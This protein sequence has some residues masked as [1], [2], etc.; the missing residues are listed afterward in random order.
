MPI[1]AAQLGALHAI[2]AHF[3]R[4]DEPAIV[5][6][7]TG[8]GKTVIGAA[9][10]Y[11]L[12]PTGRVLYIVPSRLLRR[13]TARLLSSQQQLRDVGMLP[14]EGTNPTVLEVESIPAT[15]DDLLAADVVVGLPQSLTPLVERVPPPRDLFGV[16]IVDEAHHAPAPTWDAL[17]TAFD[18]RTVLLTA[19]PYRRDLRELPGRLAY[20]YPLSKA[21]SED[22]YEPVEFVGV[23]TLGL[24]EALADREVAQRAVDLLRGPLHVG[25]DSRLLVRAK[26]KERV[27]DLAELY[28]KLG[29]KINVVHGDLQP[30]SVEA[31]IQEVRDGTA[32]GLAFVGVLGEGFDCPQ[33]KIGAYHDKHRS[34]PVTLQFLGRLSRRAENTGPAQVVSA[35]ETLKSDTWSLYRS[36]SVWADLVPQLAERAT[37]DVKRR[38]VLLERMPAFPRDDVSL[39]DID[40][41]VTVTM[42]SADDIEFDLT[43]DSPTDLG[44]GVGDRFA[45]GS[46]IWAHIDP[47]EQL[48]LFVTA[49]NDRPRWLRSPVLDADRYSMHTAL[50]RRDHQGQPLLVVSSSSRNAD[51]A[52]A[53]RIV[54]DAEQ[55]RL[56]DPDFMRR[57]LDVAELRSVQHLGSRNTDLNSRARSYTTSSGSS[58]EDGVRAEDLG[59]DVLGHV[60]ATCMIQG[61]PYSGG[62]SLGTS[63]L[64]V[65][66]SF[67]I[68]RFIEFVDGLIAAMVGGQPGE[69]RRLRTRF[70]T[71]LRHWP[72]TTDAIAVALH[73]GMLSEAS[74]IDGRYLPIDIVLEA[75]ER[76]D[77]DGTLLLTSPRLGWQ[78]KL[79]TNGIIASESH[80]IPARY[81]HTT[82]SL[83]ELLIQFPPTIYFRD[84]SSAAGGRLAPCP[85]GLLE[86]APDQFMS[87]DWSA[88]AIQSEKARS[89]HTD[90]IH[91]WMTQRLMTDFGSR[92]WVVFDDASGEVADHF[93]IEPSAADTVRLHLFHSK[94]SSEPNPGLRVK[95]LDELIGQIIRSR[96]WIAKPPGVFWG[97]VATRVMTR[98]STRL[99]ESPNPAFSRDRLQEACRRWT[100]RPPQLE[101]TYYGI[102]PGIDI[103]QLAAALARDPRPAAIAGLTETF[104]S[105]ANW[106]GRSAALTFVGSS[107]SGRALLTLV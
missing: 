78:C 103:D 21:I 40:L 88:V 1:R 26:T 55:V 100:E 90:S 82:T 38:K 39:H 102:Q 87:A 23:E 61:E 65:L 71:T 29:V 83:L 41:G 68:D 63:R 12:E 19:T 91:E 106:I 80:S 93:V 105:C 97:E 43:S 89:G 36:D 16:V 15:W 28:E 7:P 76:P 33:L 57:F 74:D 34:L 45:Q 99:I 81:G 107:P 52:L 96:R 24:T 72:T 42:F 84:G 50:L 2:G 60:G 56:A 30:K 58:I 64:W 31:R 44:L 10:P 98:A 14:G 9:A 11:L 51:F 70:E 69:I 73:A 3:T 92:A 5:A 48:M 47:H 94:A 18:A 85:D 20:D 8:V 66:E 54:G 13:Q 62:V 75:D 101:P 17:L 77:P 27:H 95:D 37:S 46:I 104:S 79:Q 86:F 6:V 32:Q 22:A 4:F 25:T 59:N 67:S 53:S 49:H 35:F